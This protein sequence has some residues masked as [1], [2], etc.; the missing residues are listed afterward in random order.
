MEIKGVVTGE[1]LSRW[2]SFT[3]TKER[4]TGPEI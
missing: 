3:I 1:F 2:D 4:L